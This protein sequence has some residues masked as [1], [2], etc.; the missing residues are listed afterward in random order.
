VVGSGVCGLT[1]S[2][3]LRE[4][5]QS[6]L[7]LDKG[8]RPGGRLAS[9]PLGG[10]LLNASVAAVIAR[11]DEVI[12]EI[13]RRTG[14]NFEAPADRGGHRE[15]VFARPAS[16]IAA[17]WA[18]GAVVQSNFVTHL[19]VK[20]TGLIQVVPHGTGDPIATRKVV[21]TAPMPQSAEI[22]RLSG[23]DV[24]PALASVT[25][26]RRDVLLCVVA[27][28]EEGERFPETSEALDLV[29]LRHRD[30]SGLVWLELLST[31]R[32][33]DSHANV[34][35]NFAHAALLLELRRLHPGARVLR[36][37]L[38]RWRY[39]NASITV[40]DATFA[41]S[42]SAPGLYLAGDAFGPE[43]EHHSGIARAV[44]SG[45]DVAAALA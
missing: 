34:D 26:E 20:R 33:S 21:L 43:R 2:H 32:W 37:T 39:A 1:I 38:K 16:D 25:Y 15:W 29:R 9:R 30:D 4:R 10:K 23:V 17:A 41:A 24:P 12:V 27:G 3:T 35:T 40:A 7:L 28:T 5:G 42:Q 36:S 22:L 13:A 18:T 14:A 45:L 19:D 31:S 8:S 44:R 11:D 6:V